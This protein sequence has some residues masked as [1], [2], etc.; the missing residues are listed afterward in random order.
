[1]KRQPAVWQVL[2]VLAALCLA[3]PCLAIWIRVWEPV[4][5]A[6]LLQ[7]VGRYVAINPDNARAHYT[8]ARLYS[9]AYARGRTVVDLIV[10]DRVTKQPLLLPDFT[11]YDRVLE[12]PSAP[13]VTRKAQ[14]LHDLLESVRHYR[15]ATQL[16][17]MQLAYDQALDWL[18]LAWMLE[19]G[20]SYPNEVTAPFLPQP[21][22][23]TADQ[24]RDQALAAYRR[25]YSIALE[26][27]PN[28]GLGMSPYPPIGAEAG[29]GIIR[30]L[31]RHRLTIPQTLEVARIRLTLRRIQREPQA[32][33]PIIFP[34]HGST[35]LRTLLSPDA[36]VSFDLAGDGG[37]DKWPW[38]GPNA[39]ILVWDP[40]QTGQIVSGRQFFGS[41]TWWMFWKD[42]YQA[43]AALDDDQNG[44]L[45]GRELDGLAVW[46]DRN[47]N[48]IA[49]PGE[50]VPLLR[51]GITRVAVRARGQ[52]EGAPFNPQGMQRRDGSFLPTYDWMP[53][54]L[55]ASPRSTKVK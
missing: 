37:G 8:L 27:D 4:P 36:I 18:G 29:E 39:G 25:A 46:C 35:A 44:W 5:L 19:Q 13:A 47:S 30:I 50:V 32:V 38:V 14:M 15:R 51:I 53:A 17:A 7:N 3:Q 52:S 40:K 34:L 21:G 16:S 42:G 12:P 49:D 23:A 48:G 22:K 1:M 31:T 41:V 54:P 9:L 24:W 20:A 10:K 11:P 2:L 45:E 33:T 55:P 6:R 43:L 26:Q 28:H